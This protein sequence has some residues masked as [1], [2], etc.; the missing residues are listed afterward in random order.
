MD[1]SIGERRSWF[2]TLCAYRALYAHRGQP[3]RAVIMSVDAAILYAETMLAF[4]R[5]S[6]PMRAERSAD[7]TV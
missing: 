3:D 5:P 1:R 4:S 2:E 7:S 6:I